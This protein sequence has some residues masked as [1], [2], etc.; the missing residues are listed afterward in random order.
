M[1]AT[2]KALKRQH[3]LKWYHPAQGGASTLDL[4]PSTSDTY[5]TGLK[6]QNQLGDFTLAVFKQKLRMILFQRKALVVGQ[7]SAMQIKPYV[8]A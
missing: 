2:Q 6:S 1:Q 4:K 7:P 3:L 5:E 8:K